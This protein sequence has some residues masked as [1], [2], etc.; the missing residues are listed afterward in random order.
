MSPSPIPQPEMKDSEKERRQELQN[1]SPATPNI[2]QKLAIF[3]QN[4]S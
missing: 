3:D 4:A 2:M 1:L